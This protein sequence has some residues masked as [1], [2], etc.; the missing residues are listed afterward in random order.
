MVH[1]TKTDTGSVDNQDKTRFRIRIIKDGPYIIYGGI[2]LGEYIIGVNSAGD[3]VVWLQ[4]KKYP[5]KKEYSLC[6]CGHSLKK[7]NCDGA[8]S[9]VAFD[10]TETAD[11]KPFLDSA[12][13]YDGPTLKLADVEKLC[14]SGRFCLPAGGTWEL[15]QRSDDPDS[16]ALA[17]KQ[18]SHCPAGR[19]VVW[20]KASG[21]VIEPEFEPSIVLVKDPQKGVSGPIWVR[22][23]IPIES[24]SGT[25]YELRNRVTLCR[26]G[27]SSNKPFCDYSHLNLNKD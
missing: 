22:G 19:I 17:I 15:I 26:C 25:V 20:D 4:G 3:A 23:G 24:S 11:T 12:E 10:G 16:R 18:V 5:P 21:D 14:A 9:K 2:P 7:P 1:Q 13:I 8:H 6:R 27:T